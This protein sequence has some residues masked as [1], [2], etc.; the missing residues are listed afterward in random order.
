MTDF[1]VI[2][3]TVLYTQGIDEVEAVDPYA[4]AL[5]SAHYMKFISKSPTEEAQHYL[6]QEEKRIDSIMSRFPSI[7][8]KI[9]DHHVR[10]LQFADHISLYICLNDPGVKPEIS[11]PFSNKAFPF[12]LKSTELRVKQSMPIGKM[13]RP[14]ILV[15]YLM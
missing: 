14:L 3:K 2:P 10:L 1:P 13:R 15:G 4:A 7:D 11:I 5:C 9:F 6:T 8:S 12:Q